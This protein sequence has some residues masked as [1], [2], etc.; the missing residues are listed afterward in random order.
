MQILVRNRT[1]KLKIKKKDLL[2]R[3]DQCIY[4]FDS[5]IGKI[6]LKKQRRKYK[7]EN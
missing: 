5:Y 6:K 1:K 4:I 7:I 3:I 2:K